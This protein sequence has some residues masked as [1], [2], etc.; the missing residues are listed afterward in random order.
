MKGASTRISAVS[1]SGFGTISKSMNTNLRNISQQQNR[2]GGAH[3]ICIASF[4]SR[5]KHL[6]FRMQI[7]REFGGMDLPRPKAY[8]ELTTPA[9]T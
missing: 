2:K 7:W 3:G 9:C 8:K 6:S 1:G 4:C 5:K